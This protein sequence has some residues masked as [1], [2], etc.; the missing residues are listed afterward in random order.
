VEIKI[1]PFRRSPSLRSMFVTKE[2]EFSCVELRDK[3]GGVRIG[4]RHGE[5]RG[6]LLRR[7]LRE[8]LYEGKRSRRGS[9]RGTLWD[10]RLWMHREKENEGIWEK[11]KD[12]KIFMSAIERRGRSGCQ[13]RP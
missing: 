11:K 2:K 13:K 1:L 7:R 8:R 12:L 9:I 3:A 4:S 6:G 5:G 10:S